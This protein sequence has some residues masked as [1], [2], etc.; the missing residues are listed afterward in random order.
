MQKKLTIMVDE[1]VY[2]GLYRVVGQQRKR[3]WPIS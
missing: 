3:L 2:D 1:V